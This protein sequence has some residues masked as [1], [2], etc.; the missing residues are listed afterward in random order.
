MDVYGGIYALALILSLTI[1]IS[2]NNISAA[3]SPA[4]PTNSDSI[5]YSRVDVGMTK[6]MGG[7]PEVLEIMKQG[8][9]VRV[10]TEAGPLEGEELIRL[11]YPPGRRTEEVADQNAA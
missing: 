6:V 4:P 10:L 3:A 7:K 9:K 8:K 5:Y 11:R 2:C 1:N